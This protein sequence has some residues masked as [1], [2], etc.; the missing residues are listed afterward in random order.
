MPLMT[1]EAELNPVF[2]LDGYKQKEEMS[3]VSPLSRKTC[4]TKREK[5][6]AGKRFDQRVTKLPVQKQQLMI[7]EMSHRGEID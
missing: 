5:T 3:P 6:A 1:S 7:T 2:L 4:A